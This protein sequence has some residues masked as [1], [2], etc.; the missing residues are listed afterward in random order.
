MRE[1]GVQVSEDQR[2]T[3]AEFKRLTASQRDHYAALSGQARIDYVQA[4]RDGRLTGE[5][6][7]SVSLMRDLGKSG[8]SL[9]AGLL[10]IGVVM[11]TLSEEPT[12]MGW[13]LTWFAAG[14][15]SISSLAWMLGA[16]ETRLITLT[17]VM[18]ARN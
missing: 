16:I 8:T 5:A 1:V 15:F 11:V 17:M 12:P 2:F 18:K 4:F 13:G 6:K 10:V 14:G 9:F 3:E 7:Q